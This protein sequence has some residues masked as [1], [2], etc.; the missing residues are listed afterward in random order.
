[1]ARVYLDPRPTDAAA[2]FIVARERRRRRGEVRP[3]TLTEKRRRALD[4][5]ILRARVAM[6][7]T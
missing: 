7:W 3:L 1:M 6:G 5:A 2:W 4:A